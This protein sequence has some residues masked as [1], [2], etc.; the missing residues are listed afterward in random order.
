MGARA[1]QIIEHW[2]TDK[3]GTKSENN[4]KEEGGEEE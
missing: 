3:V 1:F 4:K 2:I